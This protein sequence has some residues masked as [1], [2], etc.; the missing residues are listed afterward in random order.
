MN[1]KYG[2]APISL[3]NIELNP[4]E[5]CFVQYMPIR[6]PDIEYEDI[7]IPKGLRWTRPLLNHVSWRAEDYIYLTAKHFWVSPENMGNRQGWHTDGFGTTDMNY[8]WCDYLPTEFCVQDFNI[9]QDDTISLRE[10]EAQA[11]AENIVT[12]PDN[13]LMLIDPFTVHRVPEV[14]RGGLRTFVRFSVS[15]DIY[16]MHG[17]AV[18]PLF[19]YDWPMKPRT[20]QRNNTSIKY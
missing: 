9:T 6:F 7:R 16:N 1:N 4:T 5:M 20:I 8:V 13:E 15:P 18:N 2:K 12:Y 10:F 11:R 3:A 14:D 19:D 17:N